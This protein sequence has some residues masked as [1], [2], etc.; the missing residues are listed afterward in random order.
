MWF[1]GEWLLTLLRADGR[2]IKNGWSSALESEWYS[3]NDMEAEGMDLDLGMRGTRFGG[4][5]MEATALKLLATF[6]G[7]T[8]LGSVSKSVIMP[9]AS[10]R[11]VVSELL[12]V[13]ETWGWVGVGKGEKHDRT[14]NVRIPIRG[15]DERRQVMWPCISFIVRIAPSYSSFLPSFLLYRSLFF[16]QQG[17]KLLIWVLLSQYNVNEGM[18]RMW[19]VKEREERI[20][21]EWE[22][23][24][25]S[26]THRIT[27]TVTTTAQHKWWKWGSAN[28]NWWWW[29]GWWRSP[30][31]PHNQ[32]TVACFWILEW[33]YLLDHSSYCHSN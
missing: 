15:K 27:N 14:K 1:Q 20:G 3:V 21:V 25:E 23:E 19:R 24:R 11:W 29:G 22:R 2:S 31:L 4:A 13:E 5:K 16:I 8:P 10:D 9:W 17:R 32:S 28:S 18:G 7:K 12:P 26:T 30:F 6:G 33:H